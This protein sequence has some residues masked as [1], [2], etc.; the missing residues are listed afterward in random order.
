MF[1][2]VYASVVMQI[3]ETA[4]PARV[5]CSKASMDAHIIESWMTT[6]LT[7]TQAVLNRLILGKEDEPVEGLIKFRGKRI[8]DTIAITLFPDEGNF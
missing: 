5:E 7:M 1:Q 6:P 2:I 8:G 4:M 3:T